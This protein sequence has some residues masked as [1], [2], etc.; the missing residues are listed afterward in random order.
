MKLRDN[1][2]ILST[3]FPSY[4][5][6]SISTYDKKLYV[7][8]ALLILTFYLY[9]SYYFNLNNNT[10]TS[11]WSINR[12]VAIFSLL[13]FLILSQNRYLNIETIT[14]D[15]SSYLVASNEIDRGF[16]PL[17]TQWE[18]KGPLTMYIYYLISTF[19]NS[20]YVL[21]KLMND[22]VLFLTLFILLK[23]LDLIDS[24]KNRHYFICLFL[25][26]TYSN[27]WFVSEFT[28]FYCLPIIAFANYLYLKKLKYHT[29]F[30]GICFGLSFLINQGS[31]IFFIPIILMT[32]INSSD[33]KDL[34][35]KIVSY[36]S[37]LL[38]PNLIFLVLYWSNGLIDVYLANYIDI[39]L[40]YVGENMSSFYELRVFLR[41][42]FYLN[43]FLYFA[44][45]SFIFF[46]IT[47]FFSKGK[48]HF[49]K[50]FTL[51]NL[52][53]IISLLYYFIAGH[54]FYHHLIYLIYFVSFLIININQHNQVKVIFLLIILSSL[55]VATSTFQSSFKNLSNLTETYENYPLKKLA[56]TIDDYFIDENYSVL[57]LDFVLVL[58]YLDT[59]NFSYIVHPT[60]HYQ[61]YITDV[62]IDLNKIEED[63][64]QAL[65]NKRPDVIICNTMSIDTGGKVMSTDP[66]NYGND[67]EEGTEHFCS[68]GRYSDEYI[69]LDTESIRKDPNLNYYYDPYKEMNVF[70][71]S[72]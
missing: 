61:K 34:R 35:K 42:I 21:F 9:K 13:L 64:I 51:I 50:F 14:W 65:L 17:Q 48:L 45:V 11:D 56:E 69:Q 26:S 7:A 63:N 53:I 66:V 62:L 30:I 16:I 67:V 70:I 32:L 46:F 52:N 37:G 58:H 44:I 29:L 49:D 31:I 12:K 24:N 18:S 4:I 54:N 60:N 55:N 39:P 41:E 57:A 28:E 22:I 27:R 20:N 15:T 19:V 43:S 6:L 47:S 68:Y 71:K 59:T 1:L 5:Y 33:F 8:T 36:F 2:Q 3:I 25:L 38:V 10:L 23:K 72:Q 40:G